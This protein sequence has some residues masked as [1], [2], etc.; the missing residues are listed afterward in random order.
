[1]SLIER[2]FKKVLVLSLMTLV[3]TSFASV[4][5]ADGDYHPTNDGGVFGLGL[6]VGDP[7]AWG[8]DGKFWLDR[9]NAFQPAV[10]FNDGNA[11]IL[12]LDY[13]WHDF[14]IVRLS[15]GSGKLPFYIGVGGDLALQSPVSAGV[16]V[17]VGVSYIFD[18]KN[19]PVDL[20][21]QI[22]PTLWFYNNGTNL[23]WYPEFGG[24]FYL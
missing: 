24:H 9:V 18:K 4:S 15:D 3:L 7:G 22:V 6:E 23:N 11:V 8:V 13:L 14:D 1:M 19:V 12:Q 20:Y 5:R 17:P 2:N 10:K 16:R 21:F